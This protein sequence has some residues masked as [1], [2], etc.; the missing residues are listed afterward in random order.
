MSVLFCGVL[1]Y[2]WPTLPGSGLNQTI[3]M[4]TWILVCIQGVW[5]LRFLPRR[6]RTGKAGGLLLAGLLLMNLPVLWT[7]RI[8]IP[9]ALF[10]MAGTA[11]L[12][13]LMWLLLPLAV[14]GRPRRTMYVVIVAAG[15]FQAGLSC[16][17]VL[18]PASAARWLRYDFLHAG[19]RATGAFG[20]ANLLGSFLATA[21][22]CALWLML[23]SSRQW[24]RR[25]AAA[26]TLPLLIALVLSESR[27]A[28]LGAASGTGVLML[29]VYAS[30]QRIQIA[31]AIL[32]GLLA[33]MGASSLRPAAVI[34]GPAGVAV[35]K[36]E[37]LTSRLTTG[38]TE[39]N[40][41]RRIMIQGALSLIAAHPL[42]GNG[43]GSFESA[44][45]RALARSGR[46][47]PFP[48]TI[49][50]PHNE[51]L[52]VWSEGG[53]A[54]LAGLLCWL[55]LWAVPFRSVPALL[56]RRP[57]ARHVIARGALTLPLMAHVMTEFPFY[58]SAVHGV[59]MV[60]LLWLAL[61]ARA[62]RGRRIPQQHAASIRLVQ[63]LVLCACLTGMV[64][65]VTGLQSAFCIRAAERTLLHDTTP[66]AG[67][68]NP[69][70]QPERLQFDLAEENL[71]RFNNTHNVA[72]LYRFRHQAG[73][74]LAVH[75]DAYLTDAM[76]RIARA[77]QDRPQAAGWRQRGCLSFHEDPRFQCDFPSPGP[78]DASSR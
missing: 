28:W 12:A 21:L 9:E 46:A 76:M 32:A 26:G 62:R 43:S 48:V 42:L 51:L 29:C 3:N 58:L 17:Q 18:L 40:N 39:S 33:G 44:F 74:W 57:A 37:P 61:P 7:P 55:T 75:N 52:Y 65:M 35:A 47:N 45:P 53:V 63:T 31:G 56:W 68:I 27:S 14:R 66:L 41:Q 8:F 60:V 10:R 13:G 19:G 50:H 67:V 1:L 49:I 64:F 22:L 54:A 73:P 11:A 6:L 70:A 38:R 59:L 23:T 16:W 20:Q 34:A 78:A 2:P 15:L 24:C 69:L 5:L 72:W 77:Q 4:L 30:R 25:L 71:L 36:A